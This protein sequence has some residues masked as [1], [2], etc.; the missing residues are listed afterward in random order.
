MSRKVH[1]ELRYDASVEEVAAMIGDTAFREQVLANLGVLRGSAT[2]DGRGGM[3]V[4]Q[5]MSAKGLPSSARKLV[6]DE[7]ELVQTEQWDDGVGDVHVTIP[8]RPGDIRGTAIL[9]DTGSGTLETVD[10]E[11]RVSIPLVGG[12]LE[13]MVA[14]LVTH[15]LRTEQRTGVTWLAD[16]PGRNG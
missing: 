9:S 1:E 5:V 6:G 15:A 14:S 4:V 16:R 8:G 10:L 11:V 12:R 3:R 13:E 7:I 2:A